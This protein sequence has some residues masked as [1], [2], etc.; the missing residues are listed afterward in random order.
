MPFGR[1]SSVRTSLA[2]SFLALILA[3]WVVCFAA[4]E[5][6]HAGAMRA[7]REARVS[8]AEWPPPPPAGASSSHPQ[9]PPPPWLGTLPALLVAACVLSLAAGAWVSRRFTR[10]LGELA[11]GA[12]ALHNGDLDHRVPEG[13]QDE[14]AEVARAMNGMAARLEEQIRTLEDEARRKQQLLADV[15]HELRSPIATLRAMSEALREGLADEPSRRQ[16]A[17]DAMVTS[18]GRLEKLVSDLLVIARLDLHQLPLDLAPVDLRALAASCVELHRPMAERAGT[19]LVA[20]APGDPVYACVDAGRIAQVLDNLVGN[21][22]AHAGAPATVRVSVE[23]GSRCRI[24][25]ADDGCGIPAERVP[26]VFDPF[27]RVDASRS[28]A[29]SHAG[30]G[31]RIARGLVEAHGGTLCLESVEGGGTIVAVELPDGA[32]ATA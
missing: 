9:G 24:V 18:T 30:L 17:L 11:A 29:D 23:G 12:R 2:L 5:I 20:V 19:A 32:A 21:A 14:F 7:M 25:V 3:S 31:L 8:G 15:A 22:I 28:P 1:G 16:R 27:Y 4:M 10:S 13:G 6:R 26:Y